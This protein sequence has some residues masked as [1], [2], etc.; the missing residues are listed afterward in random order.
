MKSLLFFTDTFPLSG[1]TEPSFILPEIQV[2]DKSFDRITILPENKA[3]NGEKVNLPEKFCIDQTFC[4]QDLS[5]NNLILLRHLFKPFV[6]QLLFKEKKRIKNRYQFFSFLRYINKALFYK[7]YI[8]RLLINGE[9]DSQNTVFYSFWFSEITFALAMLCDKY[10]LTFSCRAHGYDLYDERVV[11]RSHAIRAYTLSKILHVYPCSEQGWNYMKKQYPTYNEKISVSYLGC[12]KIYNTF[13]PTSEDHK[14][15]TFFTCARLHSVKRLPMTYNILADVAK[16]FKD[17]H[18]CWQIIGEGDE[19]SKLETLIVQN[20]V[21]NFTVSLCGAKSNEEVHKI[22]SKKHIDW[23]ILLSESEG[24][25]ISV[26]EQLAYKIPV[27]VTNVGGLPEVV[28]ESNGILLSPEPTSNELI[29]KLTKYINNA[30]LY[31]TICNNA[32]NKWSNN[33][34]SNKNRVEFMKM[35]SVKR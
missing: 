25:S 17:I 5:C 1:L 16:Y 23:G 8:N 2:M 31:D 30:E 27:I 6:L 33:Y 18:V 21:P 15:I 10:H 35:L 29:S 14:T 4:N 22:Y 3:S 34:N 26:C 12:E 13:N 32:Y 9:I 7:A 24:L 19:R 28:D 20:H 11:F